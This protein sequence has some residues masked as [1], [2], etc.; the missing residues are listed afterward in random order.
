MSD[1]NTKSI[2][3]LMAENGC[4][5]GRM[6]EV[7]QYVGGKYFCQ[8][9]CGKSVTGESDDPISA[10]IEFWKTTN[11]PEYQS[12]LD[13]I[14]TNRLRR[15]KAKTAENNKRIVDNLNGTIRMIRMQTPKA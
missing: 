9:S 13:K 3:G 5:P 12:T 4:C 14:V 7:K 6:I 10:L 2:G 15:E 11:N 8:C 1:N